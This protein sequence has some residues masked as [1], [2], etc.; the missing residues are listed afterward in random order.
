MT[1]STRRAP[2]H[3]QKK[4]KVRRVRFEDQSGDP[5]D[6]PIVEEFGDTTIHERLRQCSVDQLVGQQ[7][8]AEQNID[9]SVD[10]VTTST[11]SEQV[12]AN[13]KQLI[14]RGVRPSVGV[15]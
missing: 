8:F 5:P 10:V 9:N 11:R 2:L 6:P 13:I 3:T 15:A 1:I 7:Y 4:V 12:T 14:R